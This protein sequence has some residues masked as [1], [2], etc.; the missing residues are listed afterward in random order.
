MLSAKQLCILRTPVVESAEF[1]EPLVKRL[2]GRH[3]VVV[4]DLSVARARLDGQLGWIWGFFAARRFHTPKPRIARVWPGSRGSMTSALG[5]RTWTASMR[6]LYPSVLFNVYQIKNLEILKALLQPTRLD[7]LLQGAPNR[8][9]R[10]C[11]AL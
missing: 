6:V 5:D 2:R 11:A 9:S 10:A 7:G 4:A 1:F 3:R 8:S